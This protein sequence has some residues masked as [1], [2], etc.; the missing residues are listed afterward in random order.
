MG[1]AS[2]FVG[3]PLALG[4]ALAVVLVTASAGAAPRPRH[5]GVRLEYQRGPRAQ[6]C[7]DELE[8]R[9]E[10]AAG[11]GR[12]PFREAGPWR[13]IIIVDKRRDGA[14]VATTTLFDD[15]GASA[16]ELDPIF[17][18]DCPH[19]VKS[20]LATRIAALLADPP[21]PPPPVVV[22]PPPPPPVVV[23]PPPDAPV[24]KR[25]TMD[26]F[27]V[28]IGLGSTIGFGI[29]PRP[30]VGVTADVGFHWKVDATPLEGVSLALGVRW[31][32]PASSPPLGGF[33]GGV[34]I[35]T[36]RVVGTFAP[37]G[38]WWKLYG[39]AVGELGQLRHHYEDRIAYP[40]GG[41]HDLYAAI[42]GR[43]G[44]EAPFAPHVGFR[45]FAEILGT[46]TPVV[47]YFNNRPVWS[48]ASSTESF[49]A[50]LY[51]FF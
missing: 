16:S 32:P 4:S 42:G 46:I 26:P 18:R 27:L 44:I 28:L 34:R 31:D 49:G 6:K 15:K 36:S 3:F 35:V 22:V 1:C 50:G 25:P 41:I 40:V 37:C 12:D 5:V 29:A 21:A 13:L 23:V 8:L 39:C 48:T 43:I 47:A 14:Y 24:P 2:F 11:L 20:M 33:F 7:P 51:V 19:L 9:G 30:A 45:G 10:V 38:H 17:G